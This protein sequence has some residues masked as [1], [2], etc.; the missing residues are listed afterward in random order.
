MTLA[1]IIEVIEDKGF[2]DPSACPEDRT[3]EALECLRGIQHEIDRL[4]HCNAQ[5]TKSAQGYWDKKREAE[6]QAKEPPWKRNRSQQAK[7]R[8]G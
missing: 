5:L 3:E 1:D 7:E 8:Y 4:E 2:L 6:R